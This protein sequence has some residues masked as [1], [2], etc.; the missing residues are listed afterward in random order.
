MPRD[1][2]GIGGHRVRH[3]G[4]V[5]AEPVRAQTAAVEEREQQ[6]RRHTKAQLYGQLPRGGLFVG[7]TDIDGATDLDLVEPGEARQLLRPPVNEDPPTLITTHRHGDPVQPTLQG[8]LLAADHHPQPA[9][10]SV[11]T[12]HRLVHDAH[13]GRAY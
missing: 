2:S 3:H 6:A 8:G 7:L 11:D 4:F 5:H 9:I 10:L 1:L 13:P 12:L